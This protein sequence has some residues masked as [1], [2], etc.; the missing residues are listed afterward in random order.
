MKTELEHHMQQHK[1]YDE[2]VDNLIKK[3]EIESYDELE[4]LLK[5]SLLSILTSEGLT[6]RDYKDMMKQF[7]EVIIEKSS[8]DNDDLE[9]KEYHS[10]VVSVYEEEQPIREEILIFNSL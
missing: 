3:F 7:D 6:M 1:E 5:P 2:Y 4:E 9:E 10:Y 8:K